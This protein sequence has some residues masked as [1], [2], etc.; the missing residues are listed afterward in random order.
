MKNHLLIIL[1]YGI[2]IITFGQNSETQLKIAPDNFELDNDD[3]R[4]I[5]DFQDIEFKKAT[6]TG[7]DLKG[8]TFH[9]K[10]K[11]IWDGKVV[12]EN[13]IENSANRPEFVKYL[14]KINDTIFKI[15]VISKLTSENKIKMD[16]IF[17]RTSTSREFKLHK[18]KDLYRLRNL[19]AESNLEI[20]L[21]KPFPLFAYILPYHRGNGFSS[22][23]D[24]GSSGKDVENWGEKFGIKHY[25]IFELEFK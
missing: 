16:F 2:S 6:I 18:T 21:D 24:V 23:C 19:A 7:N 5:I 14:R 8:K 11:E 3:L 10:A 15:K 9:L 13:T 1:F 17:P 22:Y 4:N 20:R 25:I 12:S